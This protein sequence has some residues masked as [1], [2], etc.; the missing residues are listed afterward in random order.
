MTG[1]AKKS[2]FMAT[3]RRFSLGVLAAL[4]TGSLRRVARCFPREIH[5]DKRQVVEEL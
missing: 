4:R 3:R 1:G 2:H 5:S